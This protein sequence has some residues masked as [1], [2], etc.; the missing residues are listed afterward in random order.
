MNEFKQIIINL[1]KKKL[2]LKEII[3]EIPPNQEFGDYAFPCFSLA[4]IFKKSPIEIA[5]QLEKIKL[6]KEIEKVQ[7]VGPYLNFFINKSLLVDKTIKKILKEKN[8]YGKSNYG[9]N[10][11]VV[12]ESPGPNTNKPLHLGHLRNMAL[13]ISI[14]NLLKE[15]GYKVINVDIVNDRGI[16]ICKS[17]LAYKKFAKNKMPNKKSDHFVG[18]YYVMFSQQAKDNPELEEEAKEILLKWENKDKEVISL[19]KKMN[20]WTIKGI[21]ET[22]KTFG[23]KIDKTY[24]E[25]QYYEKGKDIILKFYKKGL[26]K[27]NKL[28]AIVADLTKD[29]LGEKV[30]LREDGTSIYITQDLHLAIQRYEDYKMDKMIYIVGSEQIYHFRVLFKL[31]KLMNYK[32]VNNYYHLP[33]GMIY[34]PEGKMK[35]REGKVVDADNLIK[36]VNILAKKEIIIRDQTLTRE[37]LEKRSNQIGLAAL[38]FFILKFDPLKDFTYN[39]EESIAFEGETGP[40]L[41]YTYV[42]A[43]SILKKSKFNPIKVNYSNLKEKEEIY[44]INELL[45][46]IEVVEKAA[47]DLKPHLLCN[48][49]FELAQKFNEFYHKYQVLKAE[50][51]LKNARLGLV[52]AVSQVLSNGLNILSIETPEK[53]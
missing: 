48:Y 21:K 23:V 46:Y 13:G 14:S 30:L 29:N 9:K 20:N 8:N 10:K 4:K 2:K 53:M 27:K 51:G 18:D 5:L 47:L 22:Y 34:L 32:F 19:W 3:L 12:I 45:K 43:N 33:Y 24:F 37:E 50:E 1:L 40:Y 52:K 39:P 42:R 26:F 38:K 41:Q 36:D 6:P 15:I 31:L 11:K 16:H 35:S 7:A 28:G 25:S 44:L 49:L 17:M